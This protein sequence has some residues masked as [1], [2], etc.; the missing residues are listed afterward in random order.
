MEEHGGQAVPAG[1]ADG[2]VSPV[3][4][5]VGA[6][7]QAAGG[8]ELP[9]E[10]VGQVV[11]AE[12]AGLVSPAEE[13]GGV[14]S[15]DHDGQ[16]VSPVEAGGEVGPVEDGDGEAP[17]E[18]GAQES[19]VGEVG[20]ESLAQVDTGQAG[21]RPVEGGRSGAS[22]ALDDPDYAPRRGLGP[23][24]SAR[25]RPGRSAGARRAGLGPGD[26]SGVGARRA[27]TRGR[28]GRARVGWVILGLVVALVL[29]LGVDALAL[30]LRIERTDMI[31][32]SMGGGA[33]PGETWVIVGSDNR[34]WIVGDEDVYGDGSTRVADHA[35]I[36]IVIHKTEAATHTF[37]VP[38]DMWV[39][40]SDGG[41][42]RLTMMMARSTD[43]FVDAMCASLGIPVDHLLMV[44]M[45]TF[46][47]VVNAIGGVT[48]EFPYETRDQEAKLSV[49]AGESLLDGDQAL[50]YVRSREAEHRIDGEWVRVDAVQ[51]ANQDRPS[52]GAEVLSA[53]MDKVRTVRDPVTWQR[54]AW[55]V[56]GGMVLDSGSSLLD[57]PELIGDINGEIDVLPVSPNSGKIIA[58]MSDET[59]SALAEAGYPEGACQV[60]G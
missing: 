38:R 10:G 31:E 41:P 2:D 5:G 8:E 17:L 25:S 33:D 6:P 22:R 18:A 1:E 12:D 27:A 32:T 42:G 19:P 20:S 47:N 40:G 55:A 37:M 15:E 51:G 43:D 35:D 52:S 16:A 29:A 39:R 36:V 4:D 46:V 44:R 14:L 13:P 57:V 3:E 7:S 9:V 24:R 11:V 28:S 54:L 23:V 56:S 49:P 60:T 30:V 58:L 34:E 59:R 26:E 48:I 53:V 21:G 45:S 50:A